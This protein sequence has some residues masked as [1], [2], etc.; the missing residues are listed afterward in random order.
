[1]QLQEKPQ[2]QAKINSIFPDESSI[3]GEFQLPDPIHQTEYL[4]DGLLRHWEGS[5]Q[6]VSSSIYVKTADG[7]SQKVI[8]SVPML[9]EKE[10]LEA[11]DAAVVA[12]NNGR[13][14]WPTMSVSGRI[15]HIQ[16]FAYRMKEK[17]QEVVNL[18]MWEIG[19]SYPDSEKE[20]DRT[21]AY[22]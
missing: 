20:F 9:S 5:R 1:M 19:K 12:Y 8:G 18:L 14:H 16:D 2:L 21:I 13:G 3:P 15:E 17:K 22:I 4:I 6:E 7:F 11:L 10:A